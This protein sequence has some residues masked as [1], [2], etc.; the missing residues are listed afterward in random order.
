MVVMMPGTP[1]TCSRSVA[2]DRMI[3][4]APADAADARAQTTASTRV[5]AMADAGTRCPL[6]RR[7]QAA[8]GADAPGAAAVDVVE[9]SV[10]DPCAYLPVPLKIIVVGLLVAL[11]TTVIVPA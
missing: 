3:A 5:H 11:L 8:P 2:D 6:L 9:R 4:S 1:T 7:P 10:D